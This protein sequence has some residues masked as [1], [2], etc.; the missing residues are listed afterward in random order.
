MRVGRVTAR[1]CDNR[2]T[3]QGCNNPSGDLAGRE[4][5]LGPL[6]L[7]IGFGKDSPSKGVTKRVNRRVSA[8]NIG[9]CSR[10]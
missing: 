1:H 2:V 8:G 3:N 6:G 7:F 9:V 5:K 10:R 4:E